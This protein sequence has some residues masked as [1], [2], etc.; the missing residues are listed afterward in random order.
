[1]LIGP[2]LSLLL[3]GIAVIIFYYGFGDDYFC[4]Y[5]KYVFIAISAGLEREL[6]EHKQAVSVMRWERL[7]VKLW[8]VGTTF[9]SLCDAGWLLPL[10]IIPRVCARVLACLSRRVDDSSIAPDARVCSNT[11]QPLPLAE[12]KKDI[13]RFA[14]S[15]VS[16]G[17]RM[18]KA[19]QEARQAEEQLREAREA[20][21][22]RRRGSRRFAPWTL[23]GF[24]P[25]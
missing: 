19:E 7:V 21:R 24:F 5:F 3:F 17:L 4:C 6:S 14:L 23:V 1:M 16:K 11:R 9:L 8:R 18:R 13:S 2:T 15:K 10:S 25:R 22:R 12:S 20:R